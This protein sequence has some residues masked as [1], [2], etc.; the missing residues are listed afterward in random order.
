[1]RERYIVY[2][3][4]GVTALM[5]G[6]MEVALKLAGSDIDAF[7]LT[8]LRFL[9][10]GL[11]LLPVAFVDVRKNRIRISGKD[12]IFIILLG[13]LCVPVCM[14]SFQVGVLKSNASTAAVLLS[15]NPVFT[16]IFAH[17]LSDELFT[18]KKAIVLAVGIAGIVFMISPWEIQEGNTVSGILLVIFASFTF[19]LYT[20]LGKNISRRTGICAQTSLSFIS[21]SLVLLAVILFLGKPVFAG[22][23]DN[24][25]IVIYTSVFVTALA[26]FSF[27]M[28]IKYSDAATASIA[29]FL[30]IV[31][32]PVLAVIVLGEKVTW[33]MA[34]GIIC[35]LAAS[36][37]NIRDGISK[38]NTE[39]VR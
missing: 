15:S 4:I 21:G 26:Y 39:K 9:I 12:Y 34:A 3:G 7:Q 36:F 13:I 31:I 10:G 20:V 19:G 37:M 28:A 18:R 1:M 25:P 35:M 5:F 16:M 29:F 6:S 8:F 22:V 32:A 33:C 23:Q 24:L 14:L 27:F 38:R 2:V 30:K 11:L 17:F